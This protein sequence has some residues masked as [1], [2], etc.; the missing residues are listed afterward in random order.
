MLFMHFSRL[1]FLN[2]ST[3][4]DNVCIDRY[5]YINMYVYREISYKQ[6]CVEREEFIVPI[7]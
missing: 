5:A 4:K 1:K 7:I 3:N 6:M 2:K